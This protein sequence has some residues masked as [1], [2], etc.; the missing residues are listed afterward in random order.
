MSSRQIVIVIR[1]RNKRVDAR[2]QPPGIVKTTLCRNS[3]G[4]AHVRW[5]IWITL[6]TLASSTESSEA[7]AIDFHRRRD[8]KKF[9][10]DSFTSDIGR[11]GT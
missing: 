5:K 1:P 4:I 2:L 8:W 11:I 9:A 7:N 3:F 10:A 6:E